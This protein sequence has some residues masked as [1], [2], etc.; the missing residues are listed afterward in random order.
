MLTAREAVLRSAAGIPARGMAPS[1][2]DDG[3]HGAGDGPSP[4]SA[5]RGARDALRP[6]GTDAPAPGT[7][8]APLSEVTGPQGSDRT[9]RHSSG[10]SP[11]LASPVLAE[12]SSDAVDGFT[13]SEEEGERGEKGEG[14]E[15][16]GG[17]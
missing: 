6:S 11:S 7:R 2:E 1:R 12:A 3:C 17:G 9:V 16:A 14:E 8:P 5:A 4:Q 10:P 13:H 15:G